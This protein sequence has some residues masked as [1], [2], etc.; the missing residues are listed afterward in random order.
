MFTM[1]DAPTAP[2][3][4]PKQDKVLTPEYSSQQVVSTSSALARAAHSYATW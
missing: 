2:W 4:L 1:Q 3:I